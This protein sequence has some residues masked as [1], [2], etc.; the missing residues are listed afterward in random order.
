MMYY[1]FWVIY[2]INYHNTAIAELDKQNVQSE[3]AIKSVARRQTC[4]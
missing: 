4:T 1:C 3:E 2:I